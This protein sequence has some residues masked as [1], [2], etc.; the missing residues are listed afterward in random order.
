MSYSIPIV[1]D[2]AG[3]AILRENWL[4]S[5]SEFSAAVAAFVAT[6]TEGSPE[7]V[8]LVEAILTAAEIDSDT[9]ALVTALAAFGFSPTV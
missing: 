1:P 3:D 4:L 8:A 2:N 9:P 5:G 6:A 7:A